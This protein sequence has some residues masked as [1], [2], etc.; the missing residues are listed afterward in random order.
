MSSI[1]TML[2][3]YRISWKSLIT[4]LTGHGDYCFTKDA[5]DDSIIDLNSKHPDFHHWVEDNSDCSPE[6][7]DN[8]QS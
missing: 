7:L 3:Q 8:T 5:A 4:G 1:H 6:T 2:V